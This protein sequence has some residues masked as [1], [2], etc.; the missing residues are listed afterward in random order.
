MNLIGKYISAFAVAAAFAV[1]GLAAQG[2]PG[3]PAAPAEDRQR[4]VEPR[5]EAVAKLVRPDGTAVGTARFVNGPA[6]VVVTAE[7]ENLP[8]GVH[9]FHIHETGACEPDFEA[10]GG[11]FA[12]RGGAHG[13]LADGGPHAGDMPN[14]HVG[15][16][17]AVSV[18]TFNPYI[19]IGSARAADLFD[20][21]G[22]AIVI[23]QG[24][25]DYRSQ[26][27]GDAGDRLACGVIERG[28][29]Q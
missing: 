29:A 14:I 15:D 17:G 21:D 16:D 4:H 24:A 18:E 10:A 5:E 1:Q 13:Y 20:D 22:S 6:G 11:H 7:L 2:L 28:A 27:S 23:H 8:P 19:S 12:P 9:A 25:D 26:P 3:R